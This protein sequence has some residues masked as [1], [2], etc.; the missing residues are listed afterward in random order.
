MWIVFIIKVNN[1][2]WINSQLINTS[3]WIMF[4]IE[5]IANPLLQVIELSWQLIKIVNQFIQ[6]IQSFL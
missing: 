1:Y 3:N 4:I 6:V 5:L 2:N